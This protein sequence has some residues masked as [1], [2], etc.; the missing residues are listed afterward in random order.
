MKEITISI[1]SIILVGTF[2]LSLCGCEKNQTLTQDIPNDS[3]HTSSFQISGEPEFTTSD[4]IHTY[5]ISQNQGSLQSE[6]TLTILN[7][8]SGELVQTVQLAENE[9]FTKKPIY[10]VDVSFDGHVD[11]IV[12]H[13]RPASAA[14]F[15]AYIWD[16]KHNKYQYASHY[17]SIPN[18]AVDYN[19]KLLLSHR[20]AD[21]IT[22]YSMHSYSAE[23]SDIVVIRSIYWEPQENL[24]SILFHEFAYS[25]DG[26]SEL[27]QQFTVSAV[28]SISPDKTD[29]QIASYFSSNSIWN[30]DSEKWNNLIIPISEYN[31]ADGNDTPTLKE[32]FENATKQFQQQP[33]RHRNLGELQSETQEILL[34][35]DK[36]YQS[37]ISDASGLR[38]I[39]IHKSEHPMSANW[40]WVPIGTA[41]T[42][43]LELL[44]KIDEGYK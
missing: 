11:I 32:A 43:S 19:N 13:S 4:N 26:T 28:Y 9:W 2:I 16:V 8:T 5:I 35:N 14:Y 41:N 44:G 17:E 25:N 15:Q 39:F 22:S 42:Y 12:P 31:Y 33:E 6:K 40:D 29:S 24:N 18:I 1:L 10:L 21:K 7:K 30:L 3:P 38:Y 23:K 34:L 37:Y 20:T 27:L 36:F